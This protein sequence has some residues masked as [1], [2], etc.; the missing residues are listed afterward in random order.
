MTR[1]EHLRFCKMCL[2]KKFNVQHGIVCG[3]T[4]KIADF[5]DTCENFRRDESIPEASVAPTLQEK[6]NTMLIDRLPEHAM[7]KLRKHQDLSYAIFGGSLA[8]VVGA[9][10]WA[11]ITVRTEFQIGYMA[12]GVGL[13][14]GLAVRF[15]GAGVDKMFGYVGAVLALI[16]CLLGNLLSQVGF[17]AEAQSLAYF[18]TLTYLNLELIF[19]LLQDTFSPIDFL[20]YG[21]AVYEGYKFAFRTVTEEL[22][23]SLHKP[24]FNPLPAYHQFRLPLVIVCILALSG[25][26]F[27]INQ[28]VNGLK[29]FYYESGAKMSEGEMNSGKEEGKWSYW[30]EDGTLQAIGFYH[31]GVEEGAWQ[32]FD[33]NAQLIREGN[34]T[35]GLPHGGWV[36]YYPSG[37]VSDS[38][39]YVEGRMHGSW[40]SYYENGGI[41]Q[42]GTYARDQPDGAWTYFFDNGNLQSQ[43]K[44]EEGRMIGKWNFWLVNGQ[45][46]EEIEY[47]NKQTMRIL[48]AW[49]TKGKQMVKEGNGTYTSYDTLRNVRQTGQ[50]INGKKQG[51]WI[52]YYDNGKKKEE[53]EFKNDLYLVHNTWTKEGQQQVTGGEGLY[54]DYYD[55]EHIF[56]TGNIRKGKRAGA[57]TV[58]YATNHT[59]MQE[60]NYQEGK[61]NG[62]HKTYYESGRLYAEGNVVNDGQDGEWKWYYEN[63]TLQT[64]V[65]FKHDKKE[66]VQA[67]YGA[68]GTKTKEEV[69]KNGK[70]VDEK[71]IRE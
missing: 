15:F 10:L 51:L 20:F 58:Y 57:W 52:T 5:E 31:Q 69:Y 1:E 44:Y 42:Q 7:E 49:D 4:D 55:D 71:L 33:E 32:W 13:L 25:L 45:K 66:G 67:F 19:L 68:S 18:E 34:Y 40:M 41:S 70:L 24:D 27:Q 56:E 2:H 3:L 54:T 50:V 37:M 28:G 16:G 9:L 26:I 38:A 23:N 14:V 30:Q 59:V 46:S 21:I 8:A 47:V 39:Q 6:S 61:V 36:N 17:I 63:G 65:N 35:N 60:I 29:T 53:G 11:L 62:I 64:H 43:G 48:N 12:V 22:Q